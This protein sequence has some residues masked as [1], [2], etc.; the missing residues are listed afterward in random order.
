MSTLE[1]SG[2]Q[3]RHEFVFYLFHF[4]VDEFDPV[5]GIEGD[6]KS[7]PVLYP[8]CRPSASPERCWV[9][10]YLHLRSDIT[11][12]IRQQLSLEGFHK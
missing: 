11:R 4:K 2:P 6:V 12:K 5:F 1:C 7:T 9:F 8:R 10:G 3:M